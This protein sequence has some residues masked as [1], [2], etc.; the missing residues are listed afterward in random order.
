M[1]IKDAYVEA[2]LQKLPE[3]S[4]EEEYYVLMLAFQYDHPQTFAVRSVADVREIIYRELSGRNGWIEGILK[5]KML[6][7][8]ELT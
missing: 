8:K 4:T 3:E 1:K 5:G 2:E 6:S 7:K